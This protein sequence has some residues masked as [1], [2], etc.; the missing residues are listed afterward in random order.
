MLNLPQILWKV[1][2]LAPSTWFAHRQAGRSEVDSQPYWVLFELKRLPSRRRGWK[3]NQT[4]RRRKEE[5]QQ[6]GGRTHDQWARS[7][8]AMYLK[9]LIKQGKPFDLDAIVK[10]CGYLGDKLPRASVMVAIDWLK[11][12][13][14]YDRIV[15]E[16]S[17]RM[18]A[19]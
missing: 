6:R 14:H 1:F 2:L 4:I 16:A 9:D 17:E 12:E 15:R 3:M 5:E 18:P 13:G 8:V 11:T 10:E 7:V 19:P